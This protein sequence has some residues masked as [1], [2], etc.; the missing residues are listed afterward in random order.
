MEASGQEMKASRQVE[1]RSRL[2]MSLPE[3][4]GNASFPV[5]KAPR[6]N[7]TPSHPVLTT[8]FPD[9]KTSFPVRK[10]SISYRE[11][12]KLSWRAKN[13][14]EIKVTRTISLTR[15]PVCAFSAI[16]AAA[17][18]VGGSESGLAVSPCV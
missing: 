7:E 8:S 11:V 6:L 12:A 16:P 15:F 5:E 18:G 3:M 14:G 2:E 9:G 13:A 17:R 10:R 4:S 1:K